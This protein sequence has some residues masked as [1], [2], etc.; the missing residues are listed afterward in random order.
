MH[1]N[2]TE[3]VQNKKCRN[4]EGGGNGFEAE[5]GEEFMKYTNGY[6]STP[7]KVCN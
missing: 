6:G 5:E 3:N 2:L 1:W 7:V 4:S